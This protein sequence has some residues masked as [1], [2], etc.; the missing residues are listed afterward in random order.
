M[1]KKVVVIGAGCSGRGY[2][3]ELLY[4]DGWDVIYADIDK[5]LTNQLKAKK[6]FHVFKYSESGEESVVTVKNF[7]A[8]NTIEDHSEYIAHLADA[9]LVMTALFPDAFEQAAKDLAEAIHMKRKKGK[10]NWFTVLLGANYVGLKTDYEELMK[11]E[12]SD[13]DMSYYSQHVN[14]VESIIRR[15]NSMPT[16]EQYTVDPLSVQGEDLATLQVNK[17]VLSSIPEELLPSFIILENDT[18]KCMK[19]K[20]WQGNTLHCTLAFMGLAANKTFLYEAARDE[21]IR[22]CADKAFRE[23][24]L[25]LTK[26]YGEEVQVTEEKMNSTWKEFTDDSVKDWL[27]RVGRNPMRK[28]AKNDRFIGPALLCVQN[29]I[30]PYFICKGAAHGF[31]Y[32]NANANATSD[33]DIARLVKDIGIEASISQICGLDITKPDEKIVYDLILKSYQDIVMENNRRLS[34]S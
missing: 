32:E 34:Y 11:Q 16:E 8:V 12:L 4:L 29:G 7:E 6:E 22:E 30:M 27:I 31:L 28:L 19:T 3:G 10:K 15:I 24:N 33:Q 9:D 23:A 17:D 5:A 20:I 26:L 1:N 14:M 18:D 25:A 21:Y 2:L 13:M